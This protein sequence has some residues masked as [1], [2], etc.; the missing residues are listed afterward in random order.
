M[1]EDVIANEKMM[2]KKKKGLMKP[3]KRELFK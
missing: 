1:E 2:R 3:G